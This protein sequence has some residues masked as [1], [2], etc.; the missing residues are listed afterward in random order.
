MSVRRLKRE[1]GIVLLCGIACAHAQTPIGPSSPPA[2]PSAP[3]SVTLPVP[4][5][6]GPLALSP[7]P[8]TIAAG[9]LGTWYVDG[10]FSAL[11][12]LQSNPNSGD[13]GAVA[14][15]SNAQMFVQKI[16]GPVR[17][18]VQLGAYA[19]PALGQTYAHETDAS[20][21]PDKFFD[22][23][24]QAF[25]KI[26][27]SDA[28]SFQI[29][30][31][32]T[33]IGNEYTFT[34]ENVTIERGLLW[35]Q[36]PAVSRGI[37]ANTITGPLGFSVSLNDGFYSGRTTWLSGSASWSI[38]PANALVFAAGANLG[39]SRRNTLTTPIDQNNGSI[40]NL[41]Y[42]YTKGPL[43]VSP[44]LQYSAVPRNAALGIRNAASLFGA[45]VLASYAATPALFLGTRVEYEASSGT[46]ALPGGT[47]LL[48]GQ[49]SSAA[50]FT[51]TPTYVHGRWFL[52]TDLSAL[53]VSHVTRGYA[54]GANGNTTSQI[55]SI[56]EAGYTF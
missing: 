37:Q 5:M 40:Y 55:R 6:S 19:L 23:L 2:A 47:N 9:A 43:M 22:P 13:R 41:I 1:A 29:G 18:Y 38:N 25:L 24:P 10:A 28:L 33:L 48:Y 51:L 20:S 56:L 46:P 30:K 32:P 42:T 4:V 35:N 15:I 8:P 54:L 7:S 14:D 53:A 45:A 52:R 21:T 27:P 34:F 16:D 44:Y 50:S 39:E 12:L 3:A 31:L 11:G 36:E 49:G 17:F 26:A